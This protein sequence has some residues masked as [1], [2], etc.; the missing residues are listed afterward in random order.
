V[1]RERSDDASRPIYLADS[2]SRY[3]D[4]T[5][6]VP[7]HRLERRGPLLELVEPSRP[8]PPRSDGNP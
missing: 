1:A 3:Y 5:G 7:P 6:V 2:G 4:L 8:E